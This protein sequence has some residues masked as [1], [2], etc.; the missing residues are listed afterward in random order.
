MW[1]AGFWKNKYEIFKKEVEEDLCL[2]RDFTNN[3]RHYKL[4]RYR[5]ADY[6]NC[7]AGVDPD[8]KD[9][10]RLC[11]MFTSTTDMALGVYMQVNRKYQAMPIISKVRNNGFDGTGIFCKTVKPRRFGR[12]VSD[13]YD[14]SRQPLDRRKGF[15]L[16]YDGGRSRRTAFQTLDRFVKP[17]TNMVIKSNIRL[18]ADRIFGKRKLKLLKTNLIFHTARP[19]FLTKVEDFLGKSIPPRKGYID[20]KKEIHYLTKYLKDYNYEK[21]KEERPPLYLYTS[22]L[23]KGID[24]SNNTLTTSY[25]SRNKSISKNQVNFD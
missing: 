22:F 25:Q 11:P 3:I 14:Y 20:E 8:D 4:S 23:S 1:G 21:E 12:V 19:T 2:V 6:I 5:R 16:R 18:M 7:V 24:L 9:V 13:T 15:T 17:G 10:Y